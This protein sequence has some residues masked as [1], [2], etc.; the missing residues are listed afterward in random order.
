MRIEIPKAADLYPRGWRED[1]EPWPGY[2]PILSALGEVICRVDIP[3][4]GGHH[5]DTMVLLRRGPRC[6]YEHGYLM[7]GWGSCSGCDALL[8]CETYGELDELIEKVYNKVR[9]FDDREEALEFLRG[10]EWEHDHATSRLF[11][12]FCERYFKEY[13]K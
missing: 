11:V 10:H 13:V 7:F 2:T 4:I 3:D 8:R 12:D 9:W 6:D 1:V 5:G